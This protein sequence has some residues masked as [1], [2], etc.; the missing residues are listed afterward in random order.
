MGSGR[1]HPNISRLWKV[2]LEK[3]SRLSTRHTPLQPGEGRPGRISAGGPGGRRAPPA[4]PPAARR[5]GAPLPPPGTY[6]SSSGARRH[7]GRQLLAL[8]LL[9]F[10][11]VRRCRCHLRRRG[12]RGHP[13]RFTHVGPGGGSARRRRRRRPGCCWGWRCCRRG[14]ERALGRRFQPPPPR[15]PRRRPRPRPRS[16]PRASPD[17]PPCR[18]PRTRPARGCC[19]PRPPPASCL[20][21]PRPA[22]GSRVAGRDA[23]RCQPCRPRGLGAEAPRPTPGGHVWRLSPDAARRGLHE[24]VWAEGIRRGL[25]RVAA[26][27]RAPEWRWMGRGGRGNIPRTDGPGLGCPDPWDWAGGLFPP[28]PTEPSALGSLLFLPSLPARLLQERR[29]RACAS[30]GDSLSFLSRPILSRCPESPH[31][32]RKNL[33]VG[34]SETSWAPPSPPQDWTAR[35]HFPFLFLSS[36]PFT[37][38]SASP[39]PSPRAYISLSPFISFLPPIL[40]LFFPFISYRWTDSNSAPAQTHIP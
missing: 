39:F 36:P 31:L 40:A 7:D 5:R 22:P 14:R 9:P 8:R 10:P 20:G 30:S 11:L 3:C 6:R 25:P 18:R 38:K 13:I 26:V 28:A 23:S 33:G 32:Q 29:F 21:R 34:G 35:P 19:S 16:A 4:F 15:R 27:V 12:G 2:Q 1:G 17:A 24:R 37:A